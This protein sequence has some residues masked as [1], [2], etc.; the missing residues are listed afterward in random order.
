[1]CFALNNNLTDQSHKLKG[2]VSRNRD[3]IAHFSLL[4]FLKSHRHHLALKCLLLCACILSGV[5]FIWY[6][7]KLNMKFTTQ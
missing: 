5:V 2:Y 4:M 1:M 7:C 3:S 6:S